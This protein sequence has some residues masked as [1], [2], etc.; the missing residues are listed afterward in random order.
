MSTA[1]ARRPARDRIL[2]TASEL[3]YAHGFHAVGVDRLIAESGVA[4]ATLYKQFP[5]KDDVV[6]AYLH[7]M[8]DSWRRQLRSAALAA[9]DDPREQLFGLFVALERAAREGT[10][11]CAFI[12][13]AAEFAPGSTAHAITVEHKHAVRCWVRDLA[14]AAGAADPETLA[15]QL[16]VLIDGTLAATRVA[17]AAAAAEAAK[18]AAHDLL[19]AAC[20]R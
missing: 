19:E 6:A 15:F 8:D 10:L 12:N 3:F 16:T 13:A 7:R 9:G 1:P 17:H 4:K 5:S 18:R 14:A 2:D 20:P 11:G